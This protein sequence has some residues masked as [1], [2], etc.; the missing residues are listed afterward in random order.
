VCQSGIGIPPSTSVRYRWSRI[1]TVVAQLCAQSGV[2]FD[3]KSSVCFVRAEKF[4]LTML[5]YAYTK[6]LFALL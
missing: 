6:S 3:G 5:T 2:L 4:Q 1:I